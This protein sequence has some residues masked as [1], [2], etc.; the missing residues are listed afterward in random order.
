MNTKHLAFKRT[1][2]GALGAMLGVS[3][4]NHVS[5]HWALL[6]L[7]AILSGLFAYIFV[8]PVTFWKSFTKN[9]EKASRG[10]F[11]Y[12][13]KVG[14][15]HYGLG[16]GFCLCYVL[17]PVWIILNLSWET[18]LGM[19]L[20]LPQIIGI[21]AYN[22]TV[23]GYPATENE[24]YDLLRNRRK[25]A[26]YS[27]ILPIFLIWMFLKFIWFCLSHFVEIVYSV[28]IILAKSLAFVASLDRWVASIGAMVGYLIGWQYDRTELVGGLIGGAV[29]LG[30]IPMTRL[31]LRIL[32]DPSTPF[33][34]FA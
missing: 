14:R 18:Y 31:A 13:I 11:N 20:A 9:L 3:L 23:A 17:L 26:L 7:W 16:F 24:I 15:Y 32:P 28:A 8:A 29:S 34:K 27:S 30:L 19:F 1:L 10:K 6:T 4:G 12:L 22:E 25:A 5:N 2:A 21:G 33:P